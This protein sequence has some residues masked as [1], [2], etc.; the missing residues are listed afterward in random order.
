MYL[1]FTD[2]SGTPPKPDKQHPRY[3]VIAGIIIPESSWTVVRDALMGMK[4]RRKI[5]GEIK[6]RYFAPD[7]HD[8]KNPMRKL[9]PDERNEIRTEI[10]RIISKVG[11]M[12]TIAAVC[13]AQA[14]YQMPSIGGQE[15]IYHLTYKVLSERFQYFLQARK[16]PDGSNSMGIIVSDHRGAK[17]DKRLR[18]HHQMLLHSTGAATSQ[19]RNLI[20][21]LFL[22]P[23]DQSIGIQLADMVAGALWRAYE[24]K[25]DQFASQI[26]STFRTSTTGQILGYGIVHV[27]KKGFVL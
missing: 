11:S 20:E 27:P 6:W 18:A 24:R 16:N 10:Y 5:R 26:K 23:S 22:Q 7:N 12:T 17:D 13:C 2:E 8:D 4:I 25:D 19:Y 3:F 14:A 9:S 15:D 1:M 21:S